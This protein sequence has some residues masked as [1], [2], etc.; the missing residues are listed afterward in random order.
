MLMD[1]KNLPI[2]VD[3]GA[4]GLQQTGTPY[5]TSYLLDPV[6]GGVEKRPAVIVCPGGAY[7]FTY[8]GEAE[9]VAMQ[10]AARGFQ[11]FV[12][13]YTCCPMPFPGALLEL[14]RAI[15]ILRENAEAWHID[16]DR[17]FIVG[18][19]ALFLF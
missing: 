19:S 18:F 14:A 6:P 5:L 7:L 15:S 9:P 17:I 1:I 8:D 3:Y 11:S 12:L 16:T 2:Q 10:F 13:R 4:A